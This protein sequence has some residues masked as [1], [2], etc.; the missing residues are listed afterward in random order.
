MVAAAT[1]GAMSTGAAPNETAGTNGTAP[2]KDEFVAK[3]AA[4]EALKEKNQKYW[5]DDPYSELIDDRLSTLGSWVL[6]DR[7]KGLILT[8]PFYLVSQSRK[9][10]SMLRSRNT[11]P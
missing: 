2:I 1:G 5:E 7:R 10:P 9:D 11:Q 6:P 4:R 3:L 8:C